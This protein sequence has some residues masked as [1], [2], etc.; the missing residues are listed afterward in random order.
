MNWKQKLASELG[1][2][3]QKIIY[4]ERDLDTDEETPTDAQLYFETIDALKHM[5]QRLDQE[6]EENT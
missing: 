3:R 4:L 5:A 6:A 1:D 2:L